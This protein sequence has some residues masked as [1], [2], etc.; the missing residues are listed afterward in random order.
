MFGNAHSFL[1]EWDGP[2][3]RGFDSRSPSPP[4]TSSVATTAILFAA[5]AAHT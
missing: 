5:Y 4:P 1:P 2:D 3:K